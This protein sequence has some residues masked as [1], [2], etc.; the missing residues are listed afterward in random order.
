MIINIILS[1]AGILTLLDLKNSV[2]N[3]GGANPNVFI[4]IGIV[5][6]GTLVG[7]LL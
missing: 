4:L 5:C 7:R 3:L 2:I 6:F 1:I